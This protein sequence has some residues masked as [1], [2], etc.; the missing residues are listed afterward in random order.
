[1]TPGP[2]KP[3]MDALGVDV[4]GFTIVR[5]LHNFWNDETSL[6][7][8]AERAEPLAEVVDMFGRLW[9]R[10]KVG[11]LPNAPGCITII[12]NYAPYSESVTG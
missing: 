9:S 3:D 5:Y 1:M 2:Y 12:V 6:E 11:V 4:R 8:F 10:G 7:G